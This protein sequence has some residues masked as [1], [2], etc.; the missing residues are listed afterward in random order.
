M[1]STR[2][3]TK[4]G[5]VLD[6]FRKLVDKKHTD[7]FVL[8]NING[9][10]LTVTNYGAKIV[11]LMVPDKDGKLVDVV[12]GH[13]SIDDYLASEEPYF[14]SVCGRTANRI[15]NGKFELDGKTYSLAVNNGR[16]SLYGGIKGFN[17]VV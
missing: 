12:T 17:V 11:S 15:A 8:T 13:D 2:V 7:L 3:N 4:S 14:G 9:C 6:A 16:N 10:E 5:L 1:D